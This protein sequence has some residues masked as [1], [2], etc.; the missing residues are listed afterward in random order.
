MASG[1]E[2]QCYLSTWR[3]APF[4][5][6]WQAR[7]PPRY[8]AFNQSSSPRFPL[9]SLDYLRTW[10]GDKIESAERELLSAMD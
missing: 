3:I 1:W 6:F 8:A 5:R 9:N 7:H 2:E 10:R 4:G